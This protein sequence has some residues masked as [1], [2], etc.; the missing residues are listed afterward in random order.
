MGQSGRVVKHI[1]WNSK[2][3]AVSYWGGLVQIIRRGDVI[4]ETH[5]DQDMT[6]LAET[7]AGFLIGLADGRVIAVK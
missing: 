5:F 6:A 7:D 3:I 2:A 4:V 1:A